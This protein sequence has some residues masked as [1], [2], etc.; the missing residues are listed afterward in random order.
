MPMT[1]CNRLAALLSIM[2]V[3][4]C[5]L[6]GGWFWFTPIEYQGFTNGIP[7]MRYRSFSEVSLFGP[8]PLVVPTLIAAIAAWAVCRS[9][10]VV[11]GLAAFLLV[12]FTFI[13]GFSIGAGYLPASVLLLAA[14]VALSLGNG[15]RKS[16]GP[17]TE[18]EWSRPRPAIGSNQTDGR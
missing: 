16:A 10:R 1:S 5:V 14:V 2:S 11:L 15:H 8:V 6:I 4:W 17:T 9:H 3:A 12:M 13:S 7:T 18:R